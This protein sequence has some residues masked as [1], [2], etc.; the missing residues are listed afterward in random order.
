MIFS[1]PAFL[2]S[3]IL[4]NHQTRVCRR[5]KLRCRRARIVDARCWRDVRANSS[6]R[7]E[8]SSKSARV[9]GFHRLVLNLTPLLPP[10]G[11][12]GFFLRVCCGRNSRV[13]TYPPNVF[14]QLRA[15]RISAS[16]GVSPSVARSLLISSSIS[17]SRSGRGLY[18]VTLKGSS[19]VSSE[20][21]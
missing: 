16:S 13:R 2:I 20:P 19:T 6:N 21:G 7:C 3:K 9:R 10:S 18:S 8:R 14:R 5:L 15:F 1:F 12:K 4:R 11:Q 17:A